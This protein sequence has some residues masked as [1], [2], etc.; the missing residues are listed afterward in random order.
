[1]KRN[2]PKYLS[3]PIYI[4]LTFSQS[5]TMAPVV[6]NGQR[7]NGHSGPDSIVDRPLVR[8]TTK[9]LKQKEMLLLGGIV[10]KDN[11]GK[12]SSYEIISTEKGDYLR[13][14]GVKKNIL[15]HFGLASGV[16]TNFEK[17]IKQ[18]SMSPQEIIDFEANF[19]L[20][21]TAGVF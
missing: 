5:S 16:G 12:I 4:K 15:S 19:D 3:Q 11:Q 10:F 1:M 9:V 8:T 6:F 13:Y 17:I 21:I 18:A 14:R 7:L 20:I 2:L